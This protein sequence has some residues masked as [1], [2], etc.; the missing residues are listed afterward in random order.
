MVSL[1]KYNRI[2]GYWVLQRSSGYPDTMANWLRIYQQDEP[3]ENF[4]LAKN[5]PSKPPAARVAAP[6]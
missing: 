1:W 2:T 5:R 3:L 4:K 6:Y